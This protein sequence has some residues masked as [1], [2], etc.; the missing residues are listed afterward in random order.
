MGG[1]ALSDPLPR[2]TCTHLFGGFLLLGLTGFGGVLPL[3][4]RMLV[5]Q[6]RW[7][8]E[9]EFAELLG[10]CQFLPGGNVVNVALAVGLRFRGLTGAAAALVG[11]LAAPAT[12]VVCAG[13]IYDR[14]AA[15]PA[16]RHLLA[17]IAAGAAG[18][19]IA[20][21]WRLLMPFWS[22]LRP[23]CIAAV[24][25]L[26][27]AVFHASLVLTLVVML[28]LSVWLLRPTSPAT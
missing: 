6:R 1:A 5:D 10:L 12:I 27:I 7:L 17:G 3:A 4:R 25:A 11:L 22:R 18:L 2:P 8:T 9:P 26:A 23:L 24:T 14:Y 21:A 15:I 28:P 20:L 19:L 13:A 16:V